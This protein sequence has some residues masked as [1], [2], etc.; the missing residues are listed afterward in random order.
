MVFVRSHY[1]YLYEYYDDFELHLMTPEY[2]YFGDGSTK[3][4]QIVGKNFNRSYTYQVNLTSFTQHDVTVHLINA[5]IVSDLLLTVDLSSLASS[6]NERLV[7]SLSVLGNPQLTKHYPRHFYTLQKPS[8]K[9][10]S[11]DQVLPKSAPTTSFI[12]MTGRNVLVPD[13]S[14]S[15]LL[16][17]RSLSSTT[18]LKTAFILKSSVIMA[19]GTITIFEC[20]VPPGL[21]GAAEVA[22]SLMI[23]E[24]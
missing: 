19:N 2:L 10:S 20:T 23:G 8:F 24:L 9:L 15:C 17:L 12:E 6:H 21:S 3:E 7:V 13:K 18:V 22:I 5:T 16:T 11:P 1:S 14:T 4:L